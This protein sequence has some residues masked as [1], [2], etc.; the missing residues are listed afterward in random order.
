MI[1]MTPGSNLLAVY[2]PLP[3]WL[4]FLAVTGCMLLGAFGVLIWFLFLRKKRKRKYRH[5]H[6]K[7]PLNP[8]LAETGGLPPKRNPDEPPQL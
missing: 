5:H 7:R 4:N 8:T 1:V 2:E 3:Q 6:E